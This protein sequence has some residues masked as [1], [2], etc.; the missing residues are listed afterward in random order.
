LRTRW[1]LLWTTTI[2]VATIVVLGVNFI[3]MGIGLLTW[4][5]AA[6]L[7]LVLCGLLGFVFGWLNHDRA[8]GA[9]WSVAWVSAGSLFVLIALQY[10]VAAFMLPGCDYP[11]Q[12]NCFDDHAAA[13]GGLAAI[14]ACAAVGGFFGLT[15]VTSTALRRRLGQ[16]RA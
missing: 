14:V 6:G 1:F 11:N 4:G 10:L 9:L 2:T 15:S 13:M 16:T 8:D 12:A 5:V 3:L 7:A